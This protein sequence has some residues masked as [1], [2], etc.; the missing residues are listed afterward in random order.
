MA[1]RVF[2]AFF[3]PQTLAAKSTTVYPSPTRKPVMQIRLESIKQD[4]MTIVE[5]V[6]SMAAANGSHV[7]L[8]GA[9]EGRARVVESLEQKLGDLVDE[10]RKN[11]AKRRQ[12]N[13]AVLEMSKEFKRCQAELKES[14]AALEETK[15]A[16]ADAKL[17]I[18]MTLVKLEEKECAISVLEDEKERLSLALQQLSESSNHLLQKAKGG[19]GTCIKRHLRLQ[20]NMQKSCSKRSNPRVG[21]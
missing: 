17:E 1:G 19:R 2:R 3:I 21:N 20:L 8:N 18:Q 4:L 9:I 14:T 6:A 13:L 11:D 16:E 15:K 10:A 12:L 5:R 7:H